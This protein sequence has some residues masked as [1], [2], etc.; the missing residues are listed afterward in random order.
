MTQFCELWAEID[1][2]LNEKN[3]HMSQKLE[4]FG[5]YILLQP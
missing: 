1:I 3:R 5:N 4:D 2:F